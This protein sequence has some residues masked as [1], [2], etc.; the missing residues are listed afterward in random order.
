MLKSLAIKFFQSHRNTLLNFSPRLNV[1]YGE[2]CS[3]KTAIVRSLIL[4]K[5]NKPKGFKFNSWFSRGE[6]TEITV[7]TG[8]DIGI[9][10]AKSK[11]AQYEITGFEKPF[12]PGTGV[13]EQVQEILNFGDMNIQR[14]LDQTFLITDSPGKIAQRLNKIIQLENTDEW[15]SLLAKQIRSNITEENFLRSER[16]HKREELRALPNLK[17]I[18]KRIER[19]KKET[20]QVDRLTARLDKLES[21]RSQYKGIK[22]KLKQIPAAEIKKKYGHLARQAEQLEKLERTL[23]ELQKYKALGEEIEKLEEE[24]TET[25]RRYKDLYKKI[26]RCPTC[27]S[28]LTEAQRNRL[29]KK[30]T[31]G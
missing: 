14:Q 1:I 4:L 23:V 13:P 11:K 8:E 6:P 17:E 16:R 12:N 15:I 25:E 7:V 21:L 26:E 27:G 28:K 2:P 29:I 9:T 30:E 20:K 24:Y 19:V 18:G 5:D 10:F 22:D 3:G 31:K